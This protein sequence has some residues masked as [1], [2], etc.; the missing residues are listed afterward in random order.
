MWKTPLQEPQIQ[1]RR[2]PEPGLTATDDD[3]R[4]VLRPDEFVPTKII[5]LVRRNISVDV[6]RSGDEFVDLAC[7]G[8]VRM[9]DSL[10]F[11]FL[12]QS[13]DHH[14]KVPGSGD[15]FIVLPR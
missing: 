13:A 14:V 11:K 10:Q 4:T 3:T 7:D 1:F 2:Q 9:I 15:W 8:M 5:D 6:E 12:P